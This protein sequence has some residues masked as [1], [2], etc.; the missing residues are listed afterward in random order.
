MRNKINVA[1]CGV[2]SSHT[3]EPADR[4][5]LYVLQD[6]NVMIEP[7]PAR[8]IQKKSD[9]VVFNTII[10]MDKSHIYALKSLYGELIREKQVYLFTDIIPDM[11]GQEIPD[12]YYGTMNDFKKLYD[13]LY[14]GC[15]MWADRLIA[16][17]KA[18]VK[19]Q[20]AANKK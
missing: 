12:P 1:S 10:A 8:Y 17:Q 4:R 5:V 6:N 14:K 9:F 11:K 20:T 3:G 19:Q 15:E 18:L 2:T 13:L 16:S 7:S